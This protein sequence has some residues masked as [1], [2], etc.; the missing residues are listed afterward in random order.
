MN[1]FTGAGCRADLPAGM[2]SLRALGASN[3][4]VRARR[5]A[6]SADREDSTLVR[7]DECNAALAVLSGALMLSPVVGA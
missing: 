6:A 2:D 7:R 5:I 4:T 1:V 3:K